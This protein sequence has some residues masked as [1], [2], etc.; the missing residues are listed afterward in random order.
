MGLFWDLVMRSF[1]NILRAFQTTKGWIFPKFLMSGFRR[2][3][4]K[5]LYLTNLARSFS[6]ERIAIALPQVEQQVRPMHP[7]ARITSTLGG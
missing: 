5:M 3:V 2:K 4:I 7:S 6:I 1:Y